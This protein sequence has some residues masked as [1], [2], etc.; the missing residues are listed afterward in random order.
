MKKR[1]IV[2]FIAIISLWNI[3]LIGSFEQLRQDHYV[4]VLTKD[5]SG[6]TRTYISQVPEDNAKIG[7]LVE[8]QSSTSLHE[9][10]IC[11]ALRMLTSNQGE[12][13][14]EVLA[15]ENEEVLPLYLHFTLQVEQ[16]QELLKVMIVKNN[17]FDDQSFD[18]NTV[19][20]FVFESEDDLDA[21]LANTIS[22]PLD[23][24]SKHAMPTLS[25]TQQMMLSISVFLVEQYNNSQ[26]L[27]AASSGW[28]KNILS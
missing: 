26:K 2:S 28:L 11:Q 18:V 16:D 9:G 5:Q 10:Q 15:Q 12:Y 21:L 20:D 1:N 17:F 19:A 23:S 4:V 27:L 13:A 24:I 25:R 7:Q 8:S 3:A 22:T 14:I 6:N